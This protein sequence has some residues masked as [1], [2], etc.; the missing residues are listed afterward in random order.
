[1]LRRA[2]QTALIVSLV[3]LGALPSTRAENWPQFRGPRRDN[4]SQEKNLR[5]DWSDADLK[6][7]WSLPVC[8]GYAAAAIFGNR[9]YFNDYDEEKNLW[10]VR[11][12]GLEDGQEQWRF[13]YRRRI[14]PNHGITRTI[15]AVDENY[16]F[17][18]DPKCILHCLDAKTGKELWSKNFVADYQTRIP[19]WYNGQCPL[20]EDERVL[21]AP[22]GANALVVALDKKTGNEIWKTPNAEE[23]PLSHAS[24]MPATLG[25]VK[26][27]VWCTLKGLVGVAADD[28]RLLWSH[29]RKFNVAVAPSPLPID[30]ARVFMTSGYE[31]GSLMVRITKA[32]A[33]F[34]TEA[35]FDWT[36]PIWN[37][38]VHTP[39]LFQGHMF[40]VGKKK[41]GLFTCMDFEGR[42]DWDSQGHAS[43][44][45]GSFLLADGMFFVLEGKTGLLRI[46]DANTSEYRELGTLQVLNGHDVWAPM[47][48]S[49]GRLVLRDMTKMVCLDIRAPGGGPEAPL[50]QAKPDDENAD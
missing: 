16:V 43:F 24:L 11:C 14:R 25:G 37:S 26:Q 41:R 20:I 35:I 23:H 21:V 30:D 27:Y 29:A 19:P 2:W 8:Q 1:M 15:P 18:L 45:L 28:G 22:G 40:A 36:E 10:L 49:E 34:S 6:P 33:G 17:T 50:K 3:L 39:I 12:V 42:V 48:L 13:S 32:D 5:R 38:E 44:G 9:V 47:A 7:L 31:A 4:I 46:L